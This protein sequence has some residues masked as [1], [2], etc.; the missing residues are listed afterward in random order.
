MSLSPIVVLLLS[1]ILGLEQIGFMQVF[2]MGLALTGMLVI[3]T[4]GDLRALGGR[5]VANGDL[6]MLMAMLGWSVYTLMQSRVAAT[7]SFLG[8]VSAFA[9][10]GALLT[11]PVATMEIWSTP[12]LAFA[13]RAIAAFLFAGLVPGLLAYAGFAYLGGRF[14]SVRA[15]I[16]LYIGPI[17]SAL[18][19]WT[20]LG[21]PPTMLHAVGGILI[22]GG[23]W[24]NVRK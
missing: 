21:E 7:A 18:L 20:I 22:L 6:L 13:P 3:V 15:S 9:T 16:A 10:A 5:H 8:R 23:V 2:G 24:I 19:S 12:Q 17:A 14:G 11:L 4:R 1:R